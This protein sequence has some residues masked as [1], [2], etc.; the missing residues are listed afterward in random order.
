MAKGK[1]ALPAAL[2]A[3]QKTPK[4]MAKMGKGSRKSKK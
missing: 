2:K 1:K 3:H 4:Q